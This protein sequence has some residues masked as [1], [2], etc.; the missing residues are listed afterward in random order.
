MMKLLIVDDHEVVCDGLIT[1]LGRES[2][3][4]VE[5]PFV[6]LEGLEEL[7]GLVLSRLWSC[8]RCPFGMFG[9]QT[10]SIHTPFPN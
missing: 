3:F 9:V 6:S 8:R 2:D 10:F 7:A 1:M 5:K 4:A